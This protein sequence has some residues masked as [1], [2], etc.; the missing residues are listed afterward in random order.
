MT[1]SEFWQRANCAG[2]ESCWLWS[3]TVGGNGYGQVFWGGKL[4]QAHRVAWALVHGGHMPQ[5]CVLHICDTPLCV[6]PA[7]LQMGSRRENN[8]DRDAKRRSRRD[9]SGRYVACV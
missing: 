7:H 8:A 5:G 1:E 2:P 9:A 3:S 6:N 4:Q